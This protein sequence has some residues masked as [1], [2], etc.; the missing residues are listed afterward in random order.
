MP[1]CSGYGFGVDIR[2]C[3][4][5]AVGNGKSANLLVAFLDTTA[6]E[7]PIT[8]GGVEVLGWNGN[9]LELDITP[10]IVS[11]HG[12]A[13]ADCNVKSAKLTVTPDGGSNT[14]TLLIEFTFD[15]CVASTEDFH[16]QI[17]E[18]CGGAGPHVISEMGTYVLDQAACGT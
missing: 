2:L 1:D 5:D 10:H 4:N 9:R 12:F 11:H 13:V 18:N 17:F 7:S 6:G 16:P 8:A 3:V 15:Q 14:G